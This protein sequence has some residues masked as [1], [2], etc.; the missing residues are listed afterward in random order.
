MWLDLDGGEDS[1]FSSYRNRR[2][3][4]ITPSPHTLKITRAHNRTI[5]DSTVCN[6]R[7]LQQRK[8]SHSEMGEGHTFQNYPV[9]GSKQLTVTDISSAMAYTYTTPNAGGC[10][11]Y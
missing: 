10:C 9:T 8:L 1:N 2:G 5:H 6:Y 7:L 11:N 3:T 4:T